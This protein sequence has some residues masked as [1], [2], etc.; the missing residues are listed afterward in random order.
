VRRPWRAAGLAAAAVLLAGGAC[1]H[2]GL[3]APAHPGALPWSFEPWVIACLAAS[4]WLHGA[5][6]ARVWRR[7]GAGRGVTRLQA[8][9]FWAGWLA[10]VAALVSPLDALGGWLF[11]AHMLQH[12]V[13]MIVAAPLLVLARPLGAMSWGLPRR[14]RARVGGWTRAPAWRGGWSALTR[15][16]A[17]WSVHALALWAWHLPAA[18]DAALADPGWH[19]LQHASFFGTALLFWWTTL[20]AGARAHRGPAFASLFTTM[21]HTAALGALL[22][23]SPLVWYAPYAGTSAALGV[24]PVADQQLGG[25]VMWIPAS[26]VYLA[27]GL[28]IASTWL[29]VRDAP[30][31]AARQP[32]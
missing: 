10:L 5:G 2:A 9:S 28:W 3:A 20:G 32:S 18:F 26:L 25:L 21:I 11:S 19:A 8:A 4:A 22:S 27:A 31:A 1:A 23:L 14:W 17:A 13:L 15:P 6:T 24:D 12:E 7:A 30:A 16:L 29:R